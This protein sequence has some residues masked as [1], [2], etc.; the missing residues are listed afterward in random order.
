MRE[1]SKSIIIQEN[2]TFSAKTDVGKVRTH[3]EDNFLV[4]RGLN[5]FVVADGMGGH[6]AGEVASA[7]AVN[8]LREAV[9]E[10]AYMLDKFNK[11][12]I[13]T[14][15]LPATRQQ[16]CEIME[17][18][19]KKASRKIWEQGEVDPAKRGMGTTVSALLIAGA[20]GFIAHVGDSRIYLLRRGAVRQLTEDHS[21]INLL[22]KQGKI[23][24]DQVDQ[25]KQKNAVTRAVGVYENVEVDIIAFDIIPGDQFL[26]ASDGL[27]GYLQET[28]IPPFLSDQDL[29]RVPEKFIDMANERGGKD[30]ITSIVVR[31]ID[32]E[33]VAKD[34]CE[35][36]DLR[37]DTL[38]N[39]PMFR[40]LQYNELLKVFARMTHMA[41]P[42]NVKI[43]EEGTA[44][45]E[46]Y[47]IITG[48]VKVHSKDSTIATLKPGDHFGEM[49]LIDKS[50]RSA[51]VTTAAPSTLL[52]INRKNFFSL[53]Q[54]EADTAK[55]ILWNFL[56]VL[57]FRLRQTNLDLKDAL[58]VRNIEDLT[59]EIEG[60][61]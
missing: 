41:M 47:V 16:V 51:S 24:P 49:T 35:Q 33:G 37:L 42:E 48:E 30:N 55:K 22:L 3:N 50:P 29:D 1:E 9:Q 17:E 23:R 36:L 15:K 39:I 14:D 25:V 5:L 60:L 32:V 13:E 38:S 10:N 11:D 7:M 54:R 27:T 46:M 57:I 59:E 61:D 31:I 26:L 18:A 2:V 6:Q 43:I 53:I 28:E 19:V 21:L 58:E 20:Y 56:Q 12:E 34:K 44:G 4:D 8:F 45:D 52:K 40:Y